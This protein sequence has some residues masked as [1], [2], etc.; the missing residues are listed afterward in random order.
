MM[1]SR[2]PFVCEERKEKKEGLVSHSFFFD[3]FKAFCQF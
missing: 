2:R 3:G 1:V